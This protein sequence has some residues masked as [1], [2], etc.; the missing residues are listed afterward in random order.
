MHIFKLFDLVDHDHTRALPLINHDASPH[1]FPQEWYELL[2]LIHVRRLIGNRNRTCN[3]PN[4]GCPLQTSRSKIPEELQSVDRM[5]DRAP[6]VLNLFDSVPRFTQV[7]KDHEL[8]NSSPRHLTL[9]I[10]TLLTDVVFSKVGLASPGPPGTRLGVDRE[11]PAV[12]E[13]SE[14]P[15]HL[16]GQRT[17]SIRLDVSV[18]MA[19]RRRKVEHPP[20]NCL[21]Q[22][23]AQR[24]IL[25][26][27]RRLTPERAAHD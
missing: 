14:F 19:G 23:G 7:G 21:D 22:N 20:S 17:A 5:N 24:A 18:L 12:P 25:A 16:R 8:L 2:S 4:Q 13:A 27:G 3:I 11:E 9:A 6:A 10:T 1:I 26:A 15:R